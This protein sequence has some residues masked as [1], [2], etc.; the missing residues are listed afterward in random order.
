MTPI[1]S[2]AGELPCAVGAA[3][4]KTRKKKKKEKRKKNLHQYPKPPSF[5][6]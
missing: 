3:L 2:L 5:Q 6:G 1:Q 4:K